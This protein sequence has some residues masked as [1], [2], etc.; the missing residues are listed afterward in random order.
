LAVAACGRLARIVCW[1][2]EDASRVFAYDPCP[3]GDGS[4]RALL[5]TAAQQIA[6]NKG[7]T[8]YIPA[9]QEKGP[10]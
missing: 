6:F 8:S 4:I 5:R 3:E 1:T 2:R 10:E 9:D 7:L